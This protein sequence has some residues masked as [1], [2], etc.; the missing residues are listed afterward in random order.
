VVAVGG[1]AVGDRRHE[2][3][4][5]EGLPCLGPRELNEPTLSGSTLEAAEVEGLHLHKRPRT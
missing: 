2:S 5:I 1:Q 3:L 4:A